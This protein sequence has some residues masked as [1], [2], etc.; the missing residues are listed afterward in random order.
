MVSERACACGPGCGE[1]GHAAP[2][3]A[4]E[5]AAY[6]HAPDVLDRTTRVLR[7]RDGYDLRRVGDCIVAERGGARCFYPLASVL[8]W[9][10]P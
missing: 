7:A 1:K 3:A 6:C 4:V 5:F 2:I 9:W 8:Q 10:A